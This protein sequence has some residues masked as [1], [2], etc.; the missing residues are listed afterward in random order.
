M[1]GD[2]NW[3]DAVLVK[4][5][6]LQYNPTLIIEGEARGLDRIAAQIAIDLDIPVMRF[7]AQWSF[8][9][10]G[11]GIKRNYQMLQEGDPDLVI[12]FHDYYE[13]SKGT[14]HMITIAKERNI[15]TILIS[16]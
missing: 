6:I 10:K 2:R 11:A 13:Q 5:I 4:Q 9:G 16:H 12:G 3:T 8:Y 14:K 1:C 15:P 7:P